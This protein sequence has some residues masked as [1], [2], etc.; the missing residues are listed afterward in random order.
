[1][2]SRYVGKRLGTSTQYQTEE[3]QELVYGVAEANFNY[4]DV[5]NHFT[6][7]YLR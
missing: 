4:N 1:M 5:S 7:H 2:H 6:Y 3:P